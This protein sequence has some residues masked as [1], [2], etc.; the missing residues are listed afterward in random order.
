M[1]LTSPSFECRVGNHV[2][3]VP[4]RTVRD[5]SSNQFKQRSSVTCRE[6]AGRC[7]LAEVTERTDVVV[8]SQMCQVHILP[9]APEH[10]Q[11]SKGVFPFPFKVELCDEIKSSRSEAYP[12]CVFAFKAYATCVFAVIKSSDRKLSGRHSRLQPFDP[13]G[14]CELYTDKMTGRK[15]ALPR[16]AGS[17]LY[18]ERSKLDLLKHIPSVGSLEEFHLSD[19]FARLRL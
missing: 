12:M 14:L 11:P 10:P 9:N 3:N 5:C 13:G 7:D 18:D 15:C 2:S 1:D 16:P 19:S 17:E 6:L 4:I 8:L